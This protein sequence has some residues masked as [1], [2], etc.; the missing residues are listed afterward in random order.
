MDTTLPI[1][2]EAYDIEAVREDFPILSDEINGYPLA[3]LDSGASPQKPEVVL[4]RMEHMYRH[5]YANVHRGAYTLSQAATDHYEKARQTVAR[6]LNA[7]LL[8][9]SDAADE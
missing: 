2:D 9:T 6:Y 7:C 5:E 8:Y 4:Q 3:F 1:V